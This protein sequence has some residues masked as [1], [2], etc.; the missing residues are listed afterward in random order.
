MVA[1][2]IGVPHDAN[3]DAT[4]PSTADDG[5]VRQMLTSMFPSLDASVIDAVLR[6]SASAEQA[7]NQLL[8]LSSSPAPLSE[9]HPPRGEHPTQRRSPAP[10]PAAFSFPDEYRAPQAAALRSKRL[11]GAK[12][13]W[14][15]KGQKLTGKVTHAVDVA[16]VKVV[17]HS[18]RR[19]GQVA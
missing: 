15:Q 3:S 13:S 17:K 7:V 12:P 18:M 11:T 8:S 1:P 5:G 4:C 9:P 6:S 2:A 10:A 14:A 19:Y 16:R